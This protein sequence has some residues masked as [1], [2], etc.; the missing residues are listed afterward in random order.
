MKLS[1]WQILH[2]LFNYIHVF[3]S[4][5]SF[6]YFLFFF[7]F[8]KSV[9]FVWYEKFLIKLVKKLYRTYGNS[10]FESILFLFIFFRSSWNYSSYSLRYI[11]FVLDNQIGDILL[12]IL[13]QTIYIAFIHFH[14]MKKRDEHHHLFFWLVYK[15]SNRWCN[16]AS[17]TGEIP[18]AF[19]VR[20]TSLPKMITRLDDGRAK[21]L[22]PSQPPRRPSILLL[23]CSKNN[24]LVVNMRTF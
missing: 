5:H 11:S 24:S 14:M 7:F 8:C 19:Y 2:L 3:A 10:F 22:L 18:A 12:Y 17:A 16:V 9:L 13:F 21:K 6:I 1:K 23:C 4:L 20:C 15:V